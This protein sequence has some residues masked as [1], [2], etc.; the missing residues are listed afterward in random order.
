MI[1]NF[2]LFFDNGHPA[3][4]VVMFANFARQFIYPG[5]CHRCAPGRSNKSSND[6]TKNRNARYKNI[7]YVQKNHHPKIQKID[8]CLCSGN[9]G[10]VGTGD[11]GVGG[12]G[13]SPL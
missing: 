8:L 3:R 9:F 6:T 12:S 7:C 2:Y 5:S 4:E 11:G 1:Y 10:G 13:V